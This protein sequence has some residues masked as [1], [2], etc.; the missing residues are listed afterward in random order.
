M[1]IESALPPPFIRLNHSNRRYAFRVLKQSQIYPIKVEFNQL[2]AKRTELELLG[3]DLSNLSLNSPSRF[4]FE[5][6]IQR[7]LKSISPLIDF[8]SLEIIKHFY[9]LPWDLEVPYNIKISNKPK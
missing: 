1:E 5:S 2:I 6:Q 9:F 7:L 8:P 3:S 4:K